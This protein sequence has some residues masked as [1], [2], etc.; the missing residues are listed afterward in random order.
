MAY[1]NTHHH[2]HSLDVVKAFTN[3]WLLEHCPKLTLSLLQ[4]WVIIFTK[5]LRT[6][7][8]HLIVLK[9]LG[10]LRTSRRW[11]GILVPLLALAFL[12]NTV[13][14]GIVQLETY[15]VSSLITSSQL[16]ANLYLQHLQLLYL[17][18]LIMWLP[19]IK[20]ATRQVNAPWVTWIRPEVNQIDGPVLQTV[21]EASTSLLPIATALVWKLLHANL[22][23]KL[24]IQLPRVLLRLI[25]LQI[26]KYSI[27]ES[28]S[29]EHARWVLKALE[30]HATMQWSAAHKSRW[31]TR[32][33]PTVPWPFTCALPQVPKRSHQVSILVSFKAV[34]ITKLSTSCLMITPKRRGR[35]CLKSMDGLKKFG[36]MQWHSSSWFQPFSFVILKLII[37]NVLTIVDTFSSEN[38]KYLMMNFGNE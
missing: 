31:A 11:Y 4:I 24:L 29:M 25:S 9:D 8:S 18:L 3:F 37:L 16:A 33:Q 14:S 15:P 5:S 12:A 36:L 22:L 27:L 17:R 30:A 34:L 23:L 6:T 2:H 38:Q 26:K 19:Q 20:I 28:R 21:L 35:R 32:T 13:L 1:S 7:A 10:S